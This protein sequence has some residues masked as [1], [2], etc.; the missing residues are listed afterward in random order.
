MM[1]SMVWANQIL[2]PATLHSVFNMVLRRCVTRPIA[3]ADRWPT[4]L[5][6]GC[7]SPVVWSC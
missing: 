5:M 1:S 3:A 2:S 6:L 7:S 4:S